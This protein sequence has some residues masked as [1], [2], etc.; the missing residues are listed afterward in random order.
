MEEETEGVAKQDAYAVC[1]EVKPLARAGGGAVGLEEFHET[2]QKYHANNGQQQDLAPDNGGVMAQV[3]KPDNTTGSTI[4]D[5]MRPFVDELDII[6][7]CLREKR[8]Q[9]E[10]PNEH[11][12]EQGKRVFPYI[13]NEKMHLFFD[14]CCK[15]TNYF[16]FLQT[17]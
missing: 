17:I 5:E 13:L 9:R 14:F 12:A 6:K 4:H 10:H 2:T 11:N 15:S 16:V 3:F 7:W 1:P 8:R